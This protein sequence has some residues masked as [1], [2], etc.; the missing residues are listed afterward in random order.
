MVRLAIVGMGIRGKMYANAVLKHPNSTLE[1]ICDE[2]LERLEESRER[3]NVKIYQD[4]SKM[5]EENEIDALIVSTPDFAHKD[6]VIEAANKK[7]NILVEKPFSTSVEDAEEM[8]KAINE[9]S[10]KCMV[11]FENRWNMPFVKAKQLAE[12]GEIGDV[13]T[14]VASLNDTIFVPT[15]MLSWS[16]RSSPGWFLLSHVIDLGCWFSGYKVSHV[17]ATGVMEKLKSMG[18]NTYDSISTNLVFENGKAV[19]SYTSSWILPNT[20][21]MIYD[22]K[23]DLIGSNGAL[24]IDFQDQMLKYYGSMYQH[25]H[26]LGTPVAGYLTAAPELMLFDF[27]DRLTNNTEVYPNETDGYINTL[28]IDA[29]HRSLEYHQIIEIEY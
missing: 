9:N 28:I 11:A 8:K 21:P 26:V 1:C 4:F 5:L 19:A 16:F 23:Y 13:L 12:N 6:Y 29:I 14:M 17:Y 18:I 20:M 2:S 25:P 7:I 27:I 24:K 3:F 10:V 22:F 15:K